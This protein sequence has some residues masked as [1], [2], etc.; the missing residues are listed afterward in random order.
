MLEFIKNLF[1]F[2]GILFFVGGCIISFCFLSTRVKEDSI[3]KGD[4][5]F[6]TILKIAGVTIAGGLIVGIIFALGFLN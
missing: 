5:I 3:E 6:L 2:P 4:E 1:G